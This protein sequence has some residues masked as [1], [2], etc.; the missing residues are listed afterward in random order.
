MGY[1]YPLEFIINIGMGLH[2]FLRL[3]ANE[4]IYVFMTDAMNWVQLITIAPFITTIMHA[5]YL[6]EGIKGL[7]FAILPSS[8]RPVVYVM[9][10]CLGEF[11]FS[12][13]FLYV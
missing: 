7:N 8:P 6:P 1:R 4:D 10:R 2:L 5:M 11:V 13:T 9:L 3:L 12:S